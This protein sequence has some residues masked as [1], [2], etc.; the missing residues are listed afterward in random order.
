MRFVLFAIVL[1]GSLAAPSSAYAQNSILRISCI[2]NDIGAEVSINGQFKGECP[3]DAQVGA[4]TVKL[5]LVKKVDSTHEQVFEQDIRLGDGVVKHVE[6]VLSAPRIRADS[7]NSQAAQKVVKSLDILLK[8]GSKVLDAESI[9]KLDALVAAL[10]GVKLEVIIVIGHSDKSDGNSNDLLLS[11]QRAD[12]VKSYLAKKGIP[13]NR[14]YVEGKGSTQPIGKADENRR[15]ELEAIGSQV[16]LEA[17]AADMYARGFNYAN[18]Q[19]VVKDDVEAVT[20]FRKAAEA[21]S[22]SGMYALGI[23]YEIGRGIAKDD[24][25]AVSW[26]RKAAAVGHANGMYALGNCYANGR[27]IAKDD[28]EALSWFRKAAAVGNTNGMY[29]LG[30][31]YANGRGVAK[32]DVEAFTW[33]RKAAEAGSASGMYALGL[34]YEYGR[35]VAKDDVAAVSWYRESA[36]AGSASGMYGVG[37]GYEYG[38]GI[39]KDDV[40]A[41]SWYRKAAAAGSVNGMLAIGSSYRN[42]RGIAKNDVEAVA[43][44]RKAAVAGSAV[45]MTNLGFHLQQGIGIAKNLAEAITWYRAAAEKGDPTA[46]KNLPIALAEAAKGATQEPNGQ[47][48]ASAPVGARIRE[49]QQRAEVQ[50][51]QAAMAQPRPDQ[52][53]QP[54]TSAGSGFLGGLFGGLISGVVDR[55]TALLNSAAASTGGVGG[56]GLSALASANAQVAKESKA[57]LAEENSSSGGT[58]G[59]ALGNAVGSGSTSGAIAAFSG[60][61]N[62]LAAG[63]Q[64][65][66]GTG[67]PGSGSPRVFVADPAIHSGLFPDVIIENTS[68]WPM[69]AKL[70]FIDCVN[71]SVWCKNLSLDLEVGRIQAGQ[72]YTYPVWPTD[73]CKPYSFQ[74]EVDWYSVQDG[75]QINQSQLR[76]RPFGPF[77]SSNDSGCLRQAAGQAAT[78]S[79]PAGYPISPPQSTTVTPTVAVRPVTPAQRL[80]TAAQP[81][82]SAERWHEDITLVAKSGHS[83]SE[84]EWKTDIPGDSIFRNKTAAEK[85]IS[86]NEKLGF[87]YTGCGACGI[88]SKVTIVTREHTSTM[89]RVFTRDK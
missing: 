44:F 83:R 57:K 47:S 51:Q 69:V 40:E 59:L 34:G 74:P 71:T 2:G 84:L 14:V 82:L 89:T 5:R 11:T 43:W 7:Q 22:A 39:G 67:A 1:A 61:A 68:K 56:V 46:I 38:Q 53:A 17:S 48:Q 80:T 86:F 13:E 37:R 16:K 52:V 30:N 3:L 75:R 62:N 58:L 54:A 64:S 77:T 72:S 33:Y 49:S 50:P 4:G 26:Y 65:S 81:S 41:L 66:G 45:G 12:A 9:R 88:G 28:V 8:P 21:G 24:V 32:D 19:G 79:T 29:A 35:G 87:D 78:L 10:S 76:G 27:G 25:A 42:G 6:A 73:W 63:A 60:A 70:R 55:N 15:V 31:S 23:G 85:G 20:W 36:E 18:G